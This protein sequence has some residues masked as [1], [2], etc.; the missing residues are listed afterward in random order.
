MKNVREAGETPWWL[1]HRSLHAPR[2]GYDGPPLVLF[3]APRPAVLDQPHLPHDPAFP[4]VD[5]QHLLTLDLPHALDVDVADLP[6]IGGPRRTDGFLDDGGGT[7]LVAVE[8]HERVAVI[9]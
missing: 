8:F 9:E 4:R 7:A 2:E 1:S 5:S 6:R 3:L